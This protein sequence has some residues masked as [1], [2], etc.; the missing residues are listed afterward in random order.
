[1]II[2]TEDLQRYKVEL[3]LEATTNRWLDRSNR[4]WS[5]LAEYLYNQKAEIQRDEVRLVACCWAVNHIGA[6]GH[7][8]HPGIKKASLK[9][10]SVESTTQELK[11]L[12]LINGWTVGTT[13]MVPR[14]NVRHL[15]PAID[16]F[17]YK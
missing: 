3:I 2:A 17:F 4:F 16:P 13:I 11:E 8:Y 6:R 14:L 9:L 1:M 7:H 12:A 15:D 5:E 10:E